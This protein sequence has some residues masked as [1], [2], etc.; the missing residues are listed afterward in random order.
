MKQG[1]V[2]ASARLAG[3]CRAGL[4]LAGRSP[5]SPVSHSPCSARRKTGL[6]PSFPH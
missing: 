6:P 3:L 2:T 4:C 1:S 5:A